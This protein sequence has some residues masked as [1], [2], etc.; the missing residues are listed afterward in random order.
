MKRYIK[1]IRIYVYAVEGFGKQG[2]W[3]NMCT[4]AGKRK[5]LCARV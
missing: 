3:G 4:I 1:S 2:M 5:I